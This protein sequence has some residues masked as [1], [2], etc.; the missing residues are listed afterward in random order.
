MT[1]LDF[2]T[3]QEIFSTLRRNKL[4]TF[5]TAAGVFWG[6][7]MLLLMLA[8]GH[9]W[10]SGV[11]NRM[12]GS[13]RNAVFIWGEQTSLPFKGLQPGRPV[14]F[15]NSDV[16]AL[17]QG[18]DG[19]EYLA[20]R[21]QIGGFMGG[22]NVKRDG[23]TGSFGV[24]G[25]VPDIRH[26]LTIVQTRGRFLDDHD[27]A[28]RRKV[29]VIGDRVQE[30]MFEADEDPIG[31]YIAVQGVY[32]Q[33]VGVVRSRD[34][35]FQGERQAN[36][37]H[38][39][40][41]TFQ[42]AFNQNDRIGW[43]TMTVDPSAST[44]GVEQDAK[45][46]LAARHSVDPA[47][48]RAMGSFNAGAMFAKMQ[49]VF[50][51]IQLFLWLVGTLTLLAGVVGVSNIMLIV[52]K[53]RTREFGVRKALGATPWSVIA[54]VLQEAVVLTALAGWVGVIAGV[55]VVDFVGP[56]LPKLNAMFGPA[57]VDLRVALI[58]TVILI[59]S[60]AIAGLMPAR[61]AA[62]INPVEALRAE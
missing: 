57:Y 45:R 56:M 13:T 59:V 6:V 39:P 28:E 46:L 18:V 49:K 40:L 25:D 27:I 14:N 55:A 31:K 7:F 24:M 34:T 36:T 17:R 32:F 58:A 23:K 4:R 11:S 48:D 38:I 10:Q 33:V 15:D 43:F 22:F 29:C 20:P 37:V 50:T 9:S 19:I 21:N 44:I 1:M 61:H 8:F 12:G 2:D 42:Q 62:R 41:S 35:G 47:D 26:A 54:L 3:W 52:V 60:G 53:E 51:G 5:L 30:M 16:E